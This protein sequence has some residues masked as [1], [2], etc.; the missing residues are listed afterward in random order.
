MTAARSLRLA[1]V[2]PLPPPFGGMANQT[3]QLAELLHG[4]G[5]AVEVVPGVTAIASASEA[6]SPDASQGSGVAGAVLVVASSSM[7][8]SIL[9]PEPESG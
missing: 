2:G 7:L 3:R 4:E 8:E 9:R 6:G 1:L 5:I